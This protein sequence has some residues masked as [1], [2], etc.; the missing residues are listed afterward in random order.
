M[1]CLYW[2]V[3]LWVV[4]SVVVGAGVII[5]WVAADQEEEHW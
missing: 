4:A 3:G 5:A 2:L 1:I